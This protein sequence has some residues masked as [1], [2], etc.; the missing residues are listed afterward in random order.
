MG[1]I[2][3]DEIED[4]LI[5]LGLVDTPE[6]V[7]DIMRIIDSDGSNSVDF[8]EFF[9]VLK[10]RENPEKSLMIYNSFTSIFY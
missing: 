10:S 5:G 2:G 8:H 7:D 9:N 4:S 3:R 6:E 1:Y